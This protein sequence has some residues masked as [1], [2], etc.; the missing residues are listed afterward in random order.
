MEENNELNVDAEIR[1]PK[2]VLDALERAKAEAK[3]SRLEK[4]TL[5]AEMTYINA[6]LNSLKSNLINQKVQA[7]L[8]EMGIANSERILKYVKLEDVDLD[9]SLELKGFGDQV[10]Q[11]KADFPELFDPKLRVAGLADS[12]V[13][14]AVDTNISATEMQARSVLKKIS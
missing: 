4:E 8:K 2:A 13:N 14:S 10:E 6:N 12:G 1:D 5:E 9:E 11:I 7:Q 3:K